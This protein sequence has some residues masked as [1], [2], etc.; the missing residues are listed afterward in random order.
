[1]YYNRFRYYDPEIGQYISQDPIGLAE[2]NPTL[3]GYVGDT[4]VWIDPWGLYSLF[5]AVFG[6]EFNDTISTGVVRN[7]P[8]GL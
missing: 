4:N 2:G 3:Y 6:A 1:M 8:G 7:V 5:R